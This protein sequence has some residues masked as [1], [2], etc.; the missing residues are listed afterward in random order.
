MRLTIL[1]ALAKLTL[2]ACT[3]SGQFTVE[4]GFTVERVTPGKAVEKSKTVVE[5]K[6]AAKPVRRP[7][8]TRVLA[9]TASWCGPCQVDKRLVLTL[10]K[11]GWS[12]G[13]TEYDHV[14]YIDGDRFPE[15]RA[16]YQVRSYPTYIGIVDGK[17][18]SRRSGALRSTWDLAE[19]VR[20]RPAKTKTIERTRT[21][22]RWVL[23]DASG[24]PQEWTEQSLRQHLLTHPNHR[25][26]ATDLAG[27]SFADLVRLHDACHDRNAGVTR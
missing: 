3:A 5:S 25:Y 9:F 20:V 14:Q 26:A 1:L 2:L 6:P 23:R 10:R 18:V 19:L 16:R 4:R 24:Q 21:R 12:I 22:G 7:R 8:S 17:E 11:D 15:L 27:K 13:E